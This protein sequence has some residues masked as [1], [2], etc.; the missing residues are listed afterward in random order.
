MTWRAIAEKLR[1]EHG[2]DLTLQAVRFFFLKAIK[3][4]KFPL[5]FEPEADQE[6]TSAAA[7]PTR[8]WPDTSISLDPLEGD[9]FPK[10]SNK[11]RTQPK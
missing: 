4:K 3:R 1:D 11:P 2:I 5:G 8:K 7:T 6:G 9:P 10:T